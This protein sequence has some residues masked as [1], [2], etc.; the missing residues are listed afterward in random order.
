MKIKNIF[1][2]L[3]TVSLLTISATA[4]AAPTQAPVKSTT[5]TTT[6]SGVTKKGSLSSADGESSSSTGSSSSNEVTGKSVSS[7]SSSSVRSTDGNDSSGD[8]DYSNQSDSSSAQDAGQDSQGTDNSIQ[9]PVPTP[10]VQAEQQQPEQAGVAQAAAQMTNGKK[11]TTKGGAFLWFLLS[12]IVNAVISFMIGN[13][14]YN[15]AK[16]EKNVGVEIKA[17]RRDLEEKFA[18]NVGGFSEMETDVTNAND[19]YSEN[20]S[21]SMPERHSVDFAADSEDVFKRWDSR[22]NQK[23]R[24]AARI[25]EPVPEE[26]NYFEEEEHKQKR[27]YQP[28]RKS[29]RMNDFND[30]DFEETEENIDKS[31]KKFKAV[32]KKAKNF[33]GDI[34]PFKDE[35]DDSFDDED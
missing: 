29:V 35:D 20:G 8:E 13:R 19:N 10:I 11:Y 23:R 26:D 18:S 9:Q 28:T 17:L 6:T 3:C 33:L 25:E 15:L 2:T 31:E 30:E 34:F 21:I 12:V 22:M 4:F 14:F 27:K 24:P 7:S 16:K 32:K 1:I 5:T